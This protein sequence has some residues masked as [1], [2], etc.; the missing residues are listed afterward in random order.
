MSRLISAVLNFAGRMRLRNHVAMAIG[1]GSMV[2]LHRIAP[3]E[4]CS[5]IVGQN[6]ILNTKI[7]FDRKNAKF[8]CAD[9]C[10]IG[11]SNIVIADHVTLG[12][13]VVISWGVTIVDH[14]SHAIAWE[15]RANDIIDW[16]M[17]AKDWSNVVIAPV[18]IKDKVWIGFNAIVLKGVTI[19]EGAI[20]AAGA[21]VTKDV[22]AYTIVA[23]NPA[24]VIRNLKEA[25][26]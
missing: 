6:C 12:D 8:R 17:G 24:K 1:Q 9:R 10:Y 18:S 2:Q 26:A 4:S 16:S 13:D 14:N 7:S 3:V 5:L 23:G 11:L 25:S 20:V 19:G 22:P 21:V 15:D